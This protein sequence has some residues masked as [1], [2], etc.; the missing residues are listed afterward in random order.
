MTLAD[1][2]LLVYAAHDPGGPATQW[3]AA[4]LPAISVV[5][6]GRYLVIT[7]SKLEKK[8]RCDPFCQHSGSSC[9][10][11]KH[12]NGPLHCGNGARWGWLMR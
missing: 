10:I 7:I 6:K 1:S 5:S 4:E 8:M 9:P 11:L 12:L 2:N 3:I